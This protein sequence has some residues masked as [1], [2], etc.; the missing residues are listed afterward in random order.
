MR[1][2]D[3]ERIR[4]RYRSSDNTLHEARTSLIRIRISSLS[5]DERV[6]RAR[7]VLSWRLTPLL[8]MLIYV[9]G[10]FLRVIKR[11]RPIF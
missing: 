5:M 6:T 4:L 8:K 1:R 9:W 11:I 10:T 3:E 7:M 2:G